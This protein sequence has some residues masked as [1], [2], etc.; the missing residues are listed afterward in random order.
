MNNQSYRENV[1]NVWDTLYKY[2]DVISVNE[3]L[4]WYLPWQG[5]PHDTKWK[6]VYD[7]PLIISEFGAEAKFGNR[8]GN[9]DEARYWSEEYQEKIYQDQVEMFRAAPNLAGTC[10]WLLADY[11]SP[12]RMHPV[13]QNGYNRK[14]LLSE[15]GEKKK[16]WFVLRSYYDSIRPPVTRYKK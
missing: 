7:K 5:K 8:N 3:Y 6:L 4:G 1:L 13:F 2:F 9:T 16:A 14:G 11:R 10:A 15:H 12:G